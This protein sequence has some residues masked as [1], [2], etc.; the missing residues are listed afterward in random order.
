MYCQSKDRL[1]RP[2]P[3]LLVAPPKRLVSSVALEPV[4]FMAARQGMEKEFRNG[5]MYAGNHS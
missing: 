5:N 1:K 3:S 4:A 2:K